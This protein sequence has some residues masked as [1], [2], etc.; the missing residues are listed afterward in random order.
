MQEQILSVLVS[1]HFGVLTRVTNLF[2]RRGF[3][4]KELTVGETDDPAFS[5]ITILTQGDA[6][7]IEQIRN[8][9]AKLEDVKIVAALPED[10]LVCRE[11]L[12]AKVDF[13]QEEQEELH[14][15]ITDCG[16][17]TFGPW[18]GTL[19]IEYTGDRKEVD[20]F[21][22]KMR[23]FTLTELCRTGIAALQTGKTTL[24]EDLKNKIGGDE[25]V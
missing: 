5:R 17:R 22:K 14:R 19:V 21:I 13:G 12:L 16:G 18:Q 8:Q 25:N 2:G 6:R 4:I 15:T 9:L 24:Y 20:A 11:L 23:K 7:Q 1:N 3:N 10:S